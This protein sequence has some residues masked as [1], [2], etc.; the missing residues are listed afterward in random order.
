M[1]KID[2]LFYTLEQSD[3]LDKL[4]DKIVERAACVWHKNSPKPDIEYREKVTE[5][6]KVVTPDW[7]KPLENYQQLAQHVAQHPKLA[8]ILLANA[9]PQEQVLR[10]L[11]CGAQWSNILRVWG[12]LAEQAKQTQQPITATEQQILE[13]C[14]AL[15]NQTLNDCQAQLQWV[16]QGASY[17]YEQHQRAN[18]KG[19][20]IQAVLLQGLFN[21]ADDVVRSAVVLTQ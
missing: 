15:Y 4:I 19:E 20:R 3:M 18:T 1:S 5:K 16:E 8:A 2:K 21:A 12:A 11:V 10:F 9:Q 14:L 17:N 6:E 7:A 13:A